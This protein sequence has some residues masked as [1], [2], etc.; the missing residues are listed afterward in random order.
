MNTFKQILMVAAT[1]VAGGCATSD[2]VESDYDEVARIMGAGLFAPEGG[3]D[4]GAVADSAMLARDRMPA[5]FERS[6]FIVQ[7]QHG[8][9][10]YRY[11]VVCLDAG[12]LA[13]ASCGPSTDRALVLASWIGPL[14]TA[15][16]RGTLRRGGFWTINDPW[17]ATSMIAGSTWLEYDAGAYQ[18][19]DERTMLLSYG[20]G[21]GMVNAGGLHAAI[22]L[23]DGA[24]PPKDIDGDISIERR[25][26]T[27]TLD[28]VH[29]TEVDVSPILI[30]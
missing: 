7:G 23:R 26:A 28:G 17:H 12:G 4:L 27:I 3:G 9:A 5:G 8:D 1:V 29:T 6:G 14:D 20:S 22:T 13:V 10:T 2:V 18:L 25:I 21:Y 15:T 30:R 16:H 19:E 11:G 24:A